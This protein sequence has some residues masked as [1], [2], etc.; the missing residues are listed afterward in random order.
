[1]RLRRKAKETT[2]IPFDKLVYKRGIVPNLVCALLIFLYS[3][4]FLMIKPGQLPWALLAAAVI[5]LAAEFMS[6]L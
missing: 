4:L 3:V 1:M 6:A 5:T 2:N